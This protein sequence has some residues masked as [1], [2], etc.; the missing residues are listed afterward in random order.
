M[1]GRLSPLIKKKIQAFPV[2]YWQK[3]FQKLKKLG[4][5]LLEWTLDYK[6]LNKNPLISQIGKKK[7]RLLSK[8]YSV[9]I[10]S[11]TCDCFMQK[12]FWKIKN[13]KKILEYLKKIIESA[14]ELNIKY[15]VVPLVDK[16]S[17]QNKY[18]EKNLISICEKYKKYLKNNNVK[19]IFES[20][21]RPNVLGK[22]IKKFDRKF[23]GI[24]Y[25]TGNSASLN[26]NIDEE[27]SNY[28]KFIKNI[29][30]KDR[31]KFGK[32]VRLG[33]GNSNFKKLFKNLKKIKY[34]GNLILQTA[35]S[36]ENKH[37]EEIKI[38]LNYIRKF[39][40]EN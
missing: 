23:F 1:Q 16:G 10:N 13:N 28:G 7:I 8:K 14:G 26:Y 22:F 40:Y 15:L 4:V 34:K 39:Q 3:E 2:K 11:V 5:N 37:L 35:R 12:P 9:K 20:D 29:H 36:K 31:K 38:N 32:T 27:F 30:I 6:N 33:K 17:I 21:F 18:Q 19:I 24:N 25:D